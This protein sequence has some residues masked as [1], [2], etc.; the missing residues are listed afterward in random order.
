M[1]VNLYK[2]NHHLSAG[3]NVFDNKEK[4]KEFGLKDRNYHKTVQV[5]DVDGEQSHLQINPNDHP[6][7][8]KIIVETRGIGLFGNTAKCISE[9]EILRWSDNGNV[10]EINQKPQPQ[11]VEVSRIKVYDS[12]GKC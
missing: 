7:G 10:V 9:V 8:T 1:Y 2:S 4:A 6:K 5:V 12:V 3:V 11:W